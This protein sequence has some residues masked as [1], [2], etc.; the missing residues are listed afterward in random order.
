[1]HHE[2]ADYR[3]GNR[4]RDLKRE[5][6]EPLQHRHNPDEIFPESPVITLLAFAAY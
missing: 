1:M 3:R 4:W 5:L 2:R 6:H